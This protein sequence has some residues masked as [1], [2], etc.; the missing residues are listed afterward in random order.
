MSVSYSFSKQK[1]EFSSFKGLSLAGFAVR[2]PRSVY[3]GKEELF[4]RVLKVKSEKD[5]QFFVSIDCLYIPEGFNECVQTALK[6]KGS[7]GVDGIIYNATHTHS[8]PNLGPEFFGMVA[9]AFLEEVVEKVCSGILECL[10]INV[11]CTIFISQFCLPLLVVRRRRQISFIKKK[12]TVMLPCSPQEKEN[13]V[14]VIYFQGDDGSSCVAYS[15]ACHPVFNRTNAISGDFP[16]VVCERI[17]SNDSSLSAIFL[18]GA[19]GDLRPNCVRGRIGTLMTLSFRDVLKSVVFGKVFLNARKKDFDCFCSAL[20]VG[21]I[22]AIKGKGTLLEGDV[23]RSTLSADICSSGGRCRSFGI[24]L[25]SLGSLY[26][27]SMPAEVLSSWR[28]LFEDDS[29][30]QGRVLLLGYGEG[31]IGYLPRGREICEGGYEVV[32]SVNYGWDTSFSVDSL[33]KL[34]KKLIN[35]VRKMDLQ[36]S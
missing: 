36:Q 7:C 35:R 9:T 11:R 8:A 19:A 12:K 26:V 34:E 30:V 10:E 3:L 13:T 20:A 22:D 16:S 24:K 15:L 28:K 33:E 25:F 5:E 2:L 18:Q 27:I 6:K 4:V 32:S 31:M 23:C 14:D 17:E 29:L 21:V 1:I